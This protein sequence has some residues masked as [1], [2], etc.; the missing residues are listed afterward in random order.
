MSRGNPAKDDERSAWGKEKEAVSL[1]L[2]FAAW[3]TPPSEDSRALNVKCIDA[4]P[5]YSQRGHDDSG[6]CKNSEKHC[7]ERFHRGR[8]MDLTRTR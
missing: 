6:C 1:H 8:G 4:T 2:T 5:A 3:E 7:E